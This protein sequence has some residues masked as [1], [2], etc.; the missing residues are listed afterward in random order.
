MAETEIFYM[1]FFKYEDVSVWQKTNLRREDELKD[2][3]LYVNGLQYVDKATIT[4]Q[5]IELPKL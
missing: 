3:E 4:I 1:A 5:K 2:L